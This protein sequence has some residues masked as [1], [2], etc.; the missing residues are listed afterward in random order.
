ML[1]GFLYLIIGKNVYGVMLIC[2]CV[3]Q[4]IWYEVVGRYWYFFGVY[5][6]NLLGGVVNCNEVGVGG[7]GIFDNCVL[8]FFDGEYWSGCYFCGEEEVVVIMCVL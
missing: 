4:G 5:Y 6:S 3:L 1:W 7:D 2:K 8:L